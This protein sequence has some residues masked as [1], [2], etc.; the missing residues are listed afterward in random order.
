MLASDLATFSAEG[1]RLVSFPVYRHDELASSF[2]P[3]M[4]LLRRSLSAILEDKA[5]Q[6]PL[7]DKGQGVRVA[8]ISDVAMRSEE[9]TSELQSLMRFAYAVFSLKKKK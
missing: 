9:H 5:I 6:I 2:E 7:E 1:R 8:H 3:V 4:V